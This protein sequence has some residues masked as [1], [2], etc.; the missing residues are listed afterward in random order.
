MRLL[1][2]VSLALAIPLSVAGCSDDTTA[3]SACYDYASFNG[4]SPAVSFKTD[5]LPVFQTSCG[6]SASCHGTPM[7]SLPGQPY[8]GPPN[9]AGPASASDIDAIRAEIIDVNATKES[10]M[11]IVAPGDPAN[12]FVMHKIDNTLGCDALSCGGNCGQ[13]MPPGAP[14]T[15]TQ[16]DAIR[17]WIAQGAKND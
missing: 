4:M 9:S 14:L 2:L 8:F 7:N 10:G 11:K 1:I 15:E 16:R 12:S 17:R 13:S 6:L 5:V 3:G